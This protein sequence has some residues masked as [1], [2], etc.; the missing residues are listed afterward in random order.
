MRVPP[1]EK[2]AP[3]RPIIRNEY[4]VSCRRRQ[5]A[6]WQNSPS[7]NSRIPLFVVA[8]FV[9]SGGFAALARLWHRP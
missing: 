7:P 5:E 3:V 4:T 2:N 6:H 9:L 1:F 8:R